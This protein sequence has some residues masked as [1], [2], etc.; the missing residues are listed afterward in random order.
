M[1]QRRK[2]Y[3]SFHDLS[4]GEYM[5]IPEGTLT[6]G[7]A[8]SFSRVELL[9]ISIALSALTVAFAFAFS[10]P[11][12]ASPLIGFSL[13]AFL[14]ALPL[15]FLGVLTAFFVHELSHKFLAQ[16]Y[17]LW[18]EFRMFPLGLALSLLLAMA[19]GV[20]FAAP[21]AVMFRGGA[22]TQET[23]R[24]AAAGP[25]AN[26]VI[27][28]VTFAVAIPLGTSTAGEIVIFVCFINA[29]LAAFNLLPI[30]PLDG[31]KVLAWNG[32]AWAGLLAAALLLVI[33][34]LTRGIIFPGV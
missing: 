9:H 5:Y 30:G 16:R 31:R 22:R 1:E 10:R 29:L 13:G 3:T 4:P 15:S 25:V 11:S 27:A 23:G 26:I 24:I 8:G 18:S 28:A 12:A 32:L 19:V 7:K 20:V 2:V 17:G 33:G 14:A 6:T 34:N 21:G